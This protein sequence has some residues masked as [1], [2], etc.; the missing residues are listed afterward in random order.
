VRFER[1]APRS[2]AEADAAYLRMLRVERASWKGIGRCGMAEPPALDF[3]RRLL[4]RLACS[5]AG[6]VIFARCDERDV[7]FV[8][9]GLAGD[10][11]RGQQFSYA[12]DWRELSIGNLLQLEQ[13]RWLCEEGVPHYDMGPWMEY[14]DHWTERRQRIGTR[15]LRPRDGEAA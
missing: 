2:L 11:Y 7:G 5:A 3:Y 8:L 4:R 9:G 1:C 13:I 12:E 14:K 10:H 6:R 15:L